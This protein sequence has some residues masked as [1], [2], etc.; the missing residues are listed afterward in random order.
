MYAIKSF[1]RK[2]LALPVVLLLLTGCAGSLNPLYESDEDI[3]DP[4]DFVGVWDNGH[5]ALRA[6]VHPEDKRSL[7]I[8]TLQD[9]RMGRITPDMPRPPDVGA[10]L[11]GRLVKIGEQT[12]ID[13]MFQPD[14][15]MLFAPDLPIWTRM[16]M[17]QVHS[18]MKVDRKKDEVIL[19]Q[20]DVQ[21][22]D[23][24]L[25]KN[26]KLVA[27]KKLTADA[28]WRYPAGLK[29]DQGAVA[30]S[31]CGP[32]LLFTAEPA[33]LRRFFA[34]H[35]QADIWKQPE[36]FKHGDEADFDK[37]WQNLE[38]RLVAAQERREKETTTP[39]QPRP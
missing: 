39:R 34:K 5:M 14:H 32:S 37:R 3:M 12:F 27:H 8:Q 21:K 11:D 36:T 31:Q 23:A 4:K 33:G 35:V 18:V 22:L 20:L 19:H 16:L 10:Y 25:A 9:P 38:S 28:A 6:E 7:L 29:L 26:P 15:L 17:V 24:L 30:F 1:G 2:R 13:L